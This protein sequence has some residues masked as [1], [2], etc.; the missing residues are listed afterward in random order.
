MPLR[1]TFSEAAG[2]DEIVETLL[3][4]GF[5]AGISRERAAF[6]DDEEAVYVVHT[7]APAGEVEEMIVG[8]R[9]RLEVTDPMSGTA[10]P[11]QTDP[12]PP[13]QPPPD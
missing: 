9:A 3:L 10:T 8:R 5:E 11:V 4:A 13:H 2:A 7:D 6:G 12:V 1:V